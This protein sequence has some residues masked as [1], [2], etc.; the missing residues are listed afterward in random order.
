M[1]NLA[2]KQVLLGVTGGIAAYKSP[3]L[4]RR[5]REQGAEVRVVLTPS[6]ERFVTPLTFQAVSGHPVRGGLWDE[7]AEAAMSHIELA[8]W[9][10]LVLV[11][12][13]TADFLGR[14]AAGL[15]DDLL[16]TVCLAT[17]APIAVAPA[18]NRLMWANPATQDNVRR[19]AARGVAVLGPGSGNQACGETGEGRMLEPAEIAAAL[20]VPAGRGTGALAGQRVVVTAGPT[21]EA[22]DPVRYLTNRSSGKMGY[23]VAAAAARAGAEVVL[24]SGPVELAPPAGVR[25]VPVD[26]AAAMR[27]AVQAELPGATVF[28]AA[29]AVADYRP[30]EQAPQKI[31]KGAEEIVLALVRNPDILAEVAASSPRPFVVGFAAE[32]ENVEANARLK[33]EG[34]SLDLIAANR[35][36]ADCGFDREDNALL[37]LWP[38]GGR[39]DL[40]SGSKAELADRLVRLIVERMRAGHQAQD[41]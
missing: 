25:V 18:M 34:K 35:V 40:G 33:L 5:L 30:A 2:G 1:P 36:G 15:A 19:L 17:E 14:L 16:A 28:V 23:A 32:T 22:L 10:D 13:A 12:P 37:V 41:S 24:V 11:A 29:A 31:K 27:A 4:V 3:D 6:A 8:R 20:P 21:R 26:T 7:S 38:G 9:A 39:V